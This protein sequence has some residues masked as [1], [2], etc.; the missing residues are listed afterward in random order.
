M[1][2]RMDENQGVCYRGGNPKPASTL[3]KPGNDWVMSGTA[4]EYLI[5]LFDRLFARSHNTC[6]VGGAEEPEYR[7]ADHCCPYHRIVFTRDY[8]A[9][10]LH[11]VAHWC[12]A[13]PQRRLQTDYGY[14]YAPDGRTPA[15]QQAFEKVEVKPQ[16]LEWI[17]S[18]AAHHRFVV[19]LDNLDGEP[20]AVAPFREAVH[21]QVLRYCRD[22]LPGRAADFHDA[23]CSAYG[24]RAGLSP[25]W[26][27]LDAA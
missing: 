24:T 12:I 2:E 27:I 15:Q 17:F 7:P 6:L 19:S 21:A 11:E 5:R 14:W 22:G 9:S 20:G 23:L 3:K 18:R 13:G 1:F 16:A 25:D 8:V 26:F 10:A 4:S